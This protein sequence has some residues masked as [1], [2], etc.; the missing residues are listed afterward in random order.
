[1]IRVERAAAAKERGSLVSGIKDLWTAI[2]DGDTA[3]VR[4]ILGD[5]PTLVESTNHHG[6]TPLMHAVSRSERTAPVIRAILEAGADVN[7]QTQEGYTALHCAIDVNGEATYNSEEVIGILVAA[8]ADLKARQHYGWT[9]LLRAVVEGTAAEVKALLAAGAD[10]N[11]TM[12]FDTLPPFNAGR[13]TLMGALT[14]PAA[15]VV[16]EALLHAGAD[17]FRADGNGV[18]FFDYADQ[19]QREYKSSKFAEVVR[20]CADL[21]RKHTA[22]S[23]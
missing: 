4:H 22:R 13:T 10:P 20:R 19:V 18:T 2:E 12:P 9:P 5:A 8:G 1:L 6:L 11:E 14:N 23:F 21:A 15:E 17:P 7:R 3:A 16:V